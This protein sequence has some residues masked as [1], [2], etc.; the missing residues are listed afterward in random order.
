[1][2][3]IVSR[4]LVHRRSHL[5]GRQMSERINERVD[6]F[7]EGSGRPKLTLLIFGVQEGRCVAEHGDATVCEFSP[8]A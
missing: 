7:P 6:Y 4:G 5:S 1:M 3:A 8:G 2:F